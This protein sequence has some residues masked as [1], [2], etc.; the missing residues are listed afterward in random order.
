[1]VV[2]AGVGKTFRRFHVDRPASIQEAVAKGLR[3]I[4]SVEL[5]WGL[6]DVSF[7][8]GAG[9]TVGIVGANG[10]GKSTLLR[11]IGG[12]GRPDTGRIDV[13]GSIGALLDLGAGFHPELT[14]RENALLAGILNGLTRRQALDRLDTIVA[15]A[16]LEK[17]IDNPIRTYSSGMQMRLAF[18]VAVHTEPDILLI[19]EVLSVGDI[20]FQRKCMD[21]IAQFR[22]RGCSILLVSHE[23]SVVQDLCD[24]AIWLSGGRLMAQGPAADVV[25]QYVAH[26]GAVEPTIVE[27]PPEEQPAYPVASPPPTVV[28]TPRGDE[29]PLDEQRFGSIE[30]EIGTVRLVDG[31]G[32][33]VSEMLS[34]QAVQI[35]IAYVATRR[36]VAPI[37][38]AR[39]LREDGV[40]CCHVTTEF[41]TLSLSALEGPG[42]IAVSI[43]RLDLNS[44]RYSIDVGCYAQDWAYAYDCH[45]L[46]RALVV[47][48][49]DS[50]D[51]ILNVPHRWEIK[52]DASASVIAPVESGTVPPSGRSR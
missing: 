47:R 2:V 51:A 37:F 28:R 3:S 25:Q 23:G 42:C 14:G 19:D 8:V 30:L 38:Y 41:S 9:K 5:V 4:R 32:H 46:E 50:R 21:R 22:A 44:G 12:V 11:L 27:A 35:E 43:E 6:R 45:L 1:M 24:E 7:T 39:V 26:M 29:V 49:D 48:G 40:V 34:G 16:E 52:G 17:A 36:L 31:A 18:S 33:S 13:H 10:S 20:A 15:F